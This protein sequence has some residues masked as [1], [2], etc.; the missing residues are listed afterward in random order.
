M[1]FLSQIVIKIIWNYKA[2][3]NST[4]SVETMGI[5]I[6]LFVLFLML[7][8][9]IFSAINILTN[10]DSSLASKT[11]E[12]KIINQIDKNKKLNLEDCQQ[13]IN[14]I[15]LGESKVYNSE[16]HRYIEVV[17]SAENINTSYQEGAKEL[18]S[19]AKQYLELDLNPESEYY[20]KMIGNKLKEKAKLFEQ[21][22]KMNTNNQ[23][24][25]KLNTLL[26]KMDAVTEERLNAIESVENQCNT[27][28]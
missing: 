27:N 23:S 26:D 4:K 2:K 10:V 16:N 18:K 15:Y 28:N 7:M 5:A 17:S 21:R 3:L 11:E 22:V 1:F 14:E 24:T 19:V 25:Q 9:A 13:L 8:L 6:A 12:V 20:S